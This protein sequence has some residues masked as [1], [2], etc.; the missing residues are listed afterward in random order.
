MV[1]LEESDPRDKKPNS[2]ILPS[3]TDKY[4][5]KFRQTSVTRLLDNYGLSVHIKQVVSNY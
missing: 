2:A 4:N 1:G 5:R 3:V